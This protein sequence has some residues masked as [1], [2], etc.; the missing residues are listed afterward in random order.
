MMLVGALYM[1]WLKTELMRICVIV[2]SWG[3]YLR[4]GSAVIKLL[5]CE[6]LFIY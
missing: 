5:S 3:C 1:C 2:V 6:Y 4:S